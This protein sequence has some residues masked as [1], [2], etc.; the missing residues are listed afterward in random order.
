MINNGG[1][2]GV[3]GGSPGSLIL[4]LYLILNLN[5]KSES[6]SVSINNDYQ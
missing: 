1:L 5:M 3:S 4:N 6:V 2:W